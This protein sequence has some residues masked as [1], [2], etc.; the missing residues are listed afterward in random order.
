MGNQAE[1]TIMKNLNTSENPTENSTEDKTVVEEM[2]IGH[3]IVSHVIN[4]LIVTVVT[5]FTLLL[6][7]D[8]ILSVSHR[9]FFCDDLSLR[10]ES[11]IE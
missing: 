10:N 9:G 3:P 4:G 6:R 7:S 5:V 1:E 11:Y 2:K 8:A